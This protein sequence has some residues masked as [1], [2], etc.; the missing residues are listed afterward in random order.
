LATTFRFDG[1]RLY[2]GRAQA[3]AG[4]MPDAPGHLSRDV[5]FFALL[6]ASLALFET[7]SLV[8][9]LPMQAGAAAFILPLC[10]LTPASIGIHRSKAWTRDWESRHG[11]WRK[12]NDDHSPP[13]DEPLPPTAP[14]RRPSAPA[15]QKELAEV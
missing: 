11:W 6:V 14:Q 10:W 2:R 12:S 3:L 13:P 5:R 8:V 4:D 15:R 7:A 1:A 9:T